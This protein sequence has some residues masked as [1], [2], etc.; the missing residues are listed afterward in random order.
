MFN[1]ESFLTLYS[2][3]Y[4]TKYQC[5]LLKVFIVILQMLLQV[6]STLS[7][8]SRSSILKSSPLSAC[9]NTAPQNT[10]FLSWFDVS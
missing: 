2:L 8:E 5:N 1:F 6:D 10:P 7:K 9:V 4:C 3:N